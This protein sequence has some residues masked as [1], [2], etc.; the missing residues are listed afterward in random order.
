MTSLSGPNSPTVLTT[1]D[2]LDQIAAHTTDLGHRIDEVSA[3]VRAA[4]DDLAAALPGS[5]A[6][7][8]APASGSAVAEVLAAEASRLRSI[9]RSIATAADSYRANEH[10][11]ASRAGA[12]G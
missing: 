5:A 11:L 12:I 4:L 8:S 10:A 1:P 3:A 2:Q 7:A 9:G 6:A